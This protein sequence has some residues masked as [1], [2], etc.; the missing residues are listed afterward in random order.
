MPEDVEANRTAADPSPPLTSHEDERHF[1]DSESSEAQD[2]SQ[3]T[4][5]VS[6]DHERGKEEDDQDPNVVTWSSPD[7][8][9]NPR[10][11][12][13]WRKKS[14]IGVVSV[15]AFLSPLSSSMIAPALPLLREDFNVTS[16]VVENMMLSVFI[17]G[18]AIMPLLIAPLSEVYG[19]KNL[20]QSCNAFFLLFTLIC[21]FAQSAPQ[22][23]VF[24][25][26]AGLGGSA[27]LALG[28]GTIADLH[29]PEERGVAV[30][31]YTLLT[32][33]GPAVGPIMG[34]WIIQSLDRGDRWRWIFWITAMFGSVIALVGLCIYPETYAPRILQLKRMK[35]EKETG[36]KDLVTVFEKERGREGLRVRLKRNLTRPFLMLGTKPIVQILALYSEFSQD[37]K[38]RSLWLTP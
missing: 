38:L 1:Q 3:H 37:G 13:K 14:I 7:S 4:A 12:S 15:Y 10:N 34:G 24:R 30:S 19:R 2:S 28:A 26:L 33:L 31:S 22:L 5:V 29:A 16:S 18:Y 17:L 25:L 23:I 9:E 8:P 32:L 6:G 21:G 27:P 11:W 35:I 36:Q 20:L